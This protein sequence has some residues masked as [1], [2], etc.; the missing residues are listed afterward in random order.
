MTETTDAYLKKL[1]GIIEGQ[2]DVI[3]YAFAINGRV[4]SADV[5]ASNALF[6]KLWPKLLKA[7]A[8]EA[9]SELNRSKN[10]PEV[11][12]EQVRA[13]LSASADGKASESSINERT[14]LLTRETDE[15]IF[16]ESRDTKQK[17]MWVHRSY[18]RK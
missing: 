10:S 5:Y 8:V 17:E 18:I 2:A 7:T 14:K 1:S 13:F 15:N 16:L 9:V 3:G 12:D 4:N 11:R 6:K